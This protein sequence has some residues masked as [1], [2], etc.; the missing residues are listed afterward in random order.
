MNLL[1]LPHPL[2]FSAS[3]AFEQSYG[4]IDGDSASGAEMVCLISAITGIP[5]RQGM[6]MTGAIDQHGH[7]EAV[8]GV[9]EK[10]EGFFDVC[11]HF[12][13]NGD[14]GVVIPRANAGD[15]MLRRDLVDACRNGQFCVYA[16]GTIGEALELM[17]GVPAGEYGAEGY[18][19]GTL[20]GM[21]VEKAGEYWRRTLASPD[22]LTSIRRDDS[23]S[24]PNIAARPEVPER[25]T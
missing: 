24:T 16:V 19:A 4:G 18:P 21:A 2:A 11:R 25:E 12:G 23:S 13:L 5:I 15:L 14:Q 7:I 22:Q 8:G 9:T 10:V 6:A 3:L 1:R 20:L 17:T